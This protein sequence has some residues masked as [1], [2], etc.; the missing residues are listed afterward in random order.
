MLT[1]MT[2]F[3][4]NILDLNRVSSNKYKSWFRFIRKNLGH[5]SE[6]IEDWQESIKFSICYK[7]L[8]NV[9]YCLL[10]LSWLFP[11][12]DIQIIGQHCGHAA[13]LDDR[14]N[15]LCSNLDLVGGRDHS[16]IKGLRLSG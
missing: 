2:K 9:R 4:Q 12:G 16:S 15:T 3:F 6:Q 8:P 13:A 11:L 14:V 7:I 10:Y 1:T 5:V